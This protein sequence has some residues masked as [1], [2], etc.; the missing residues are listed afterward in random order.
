[1]DQG[2]RP[3]SSSL[4]PSTAAGHPGAQV[5][6]QLDFENWVGSEKL[7]QA[8][9]STLAWLSSFGAGVLFLVAL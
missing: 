9:A 6:M 5:K 4:F 8:M 2:E 1:M 3:I 7:N